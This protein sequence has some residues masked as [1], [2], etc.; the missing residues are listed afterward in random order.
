MEMEKKKLTVLEF[1]KLAGVK[2]HS[3]YAWIAD[4]LIVTETRYRGLKKEFYIDP[5]ELDKLKIK[6]GI[7]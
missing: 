7:A 6:K 2:R 5:E 3:V 4:G 1:A